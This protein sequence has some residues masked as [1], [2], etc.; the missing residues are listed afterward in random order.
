[1]LSGGTMLGAVRHHGFIPWDDDVDIALWTKYY[2]L[3]RA[4]MIKNLPPYLRLIEPLD[5]SPN[6]YD[7]VYRVVDTRYIMH[8]MT[9][10]DLF[11]NNLQNYVGVDIFLI[12]YGSNSLCGLKIISLFE[13]T[14]Y[15]LAMGHR[16]EICRKDYTLLQYYQ[17]RFLSLLGKYISMKK[18]H[19]LREKLLM[20]KK[21]KKKYCSIIND[22]PRYIGLPYQ[23]NWLEEV[24]YQTFE[25][26]SFPIPIGYD[27]KMTMQ[28]GDYLTPVKDNELYKQHL[29]EL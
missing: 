9:E 7:F 8:E 11:Y 15:G 10:E 17:V 2:P 18:I 22:L 14:I 28:Y 1:M 6:F 24:I 21:K 16:Y 20:K 3:F 26:Q 23:S 25:H 19:F 12:T 5:F 13:K 29:I 27:Q 4:A